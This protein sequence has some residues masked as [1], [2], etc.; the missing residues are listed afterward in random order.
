[1]LT[2]VSKRKIDAWD[3]ELNPTGSVRLPS[4]IQHMSAYNDKVGIVTH[5]REALIWHIG[6]ALKQLDTTG[7]Q[8]KIDGF[9]RWEI[10]TVLFHPVSR[11]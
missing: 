9:D 11:T 4:G 3:L 5:G 1:M 6:G 2:C 8:E 10:S 7:V